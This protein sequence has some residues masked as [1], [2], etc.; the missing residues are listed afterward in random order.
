MFGRFLVSHRRC[1]CPAP[2]PP[3]R[4]SSSSAPSAPLDLRPFF[5][6]PED[7]RTNWFPGHMQKG[8]R[9]MQHAISQAD[10]VIEVHDARI[11]FSGR[12]ASFK[13]QVVPTHPTPARE[14]LGEKKY[15]FGEKATSIH[16]SID[17]SLAGDRIPAPHPGVEQARPG[18][19]LRRRVHHQGHQ[20]VGSRPVAGRLHQRQGQQ[21][22]GCQEGEKV[23]R[24][25]IPRKEGHGL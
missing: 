15:V 23:K 9:Q 10:C 14:P 22:Q 16:P 1:S 6:F 8:L 3:R 12:N 20:A 2:R 17:P 24:V 21:L 7:H 18:W 11:P 19:R 13:S 25:F 5:R 4:T